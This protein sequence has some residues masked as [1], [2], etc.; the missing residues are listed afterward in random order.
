MYIIILLFFS[1]VGL[2]LPQPD[3]LIVDMSEEEI[4]VLWQDP[5]DAPSNFKYNVQ[6]GKYV[7][8]I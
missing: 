7:Q 2:N 4:I 5:V 3:K 6:M 8:L 1:G